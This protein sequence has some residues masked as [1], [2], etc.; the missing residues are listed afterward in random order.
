MKNEGKN[1]SVA[2]RILF[3]IYIFSNDVHSTAL[4]VYLCTYV[5]YFRHCISCNSAYCTSG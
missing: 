2:F 3:S 4:S 1:K 5:T